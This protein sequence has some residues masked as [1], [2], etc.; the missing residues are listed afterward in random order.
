M[1]TVLR[2]LSRLY[3]VGAAMRGAAYRR[4]WLRRRR[5]NH[6]VISVGNL[7]AGG[8][9]KT[10][11]VRW[12]VERLQARGFRPAIL[13][14]GYR[15]QNGPDAIVVPPKPGRAPE[16]REVGDEAAWLARELPAVPIGVSADR[17]TTGR[18]IEENYP[19]DV[20]VLDDGFQHL[21]LGRDLDVVVLDA[22]RGISDREV[23]PAGLQR[24]P[25]SAL[26]RADVVVI[27]RAELADPA[28]LEAA[29]R[30]VRPGARLARARTRLERLGDLASGKAL[31]VEEWRGRPVHA[32]CGI[33]NPEAFFSDLRRWGF[34]VVRE[35]VFPDH[36]A[37]RNLNFAR[38]SPGGE[39]AALLTTEK[40]LMNL[41]GLKI[42]EVG[43]PVLACVTR[44]EIDDEVEFDAALFSQLSRSGGEVESRT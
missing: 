1:S 38:T 22:T 40:D 7:T 17:Y 30:G 43:V 11:L 25:C 2:P 44:L 16:P 26:G 13:T 37:Y 20:F 41:Q 15:R 3:G 34:D 18:L 6:P 8:T 24:E 14:R 27:S 33:G 39:V 29:V 35:S 19:V 9:G 12:I 32:F 28:P 42:S 10:P 4:G 31:S 21:A 36:F 23:L 5:L